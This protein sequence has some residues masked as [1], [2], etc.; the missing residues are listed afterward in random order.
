MSTVCIFDIYFLLYD[1]SEVHSYNVSQGYVMKPMNQSVQPFDQEMEPAEVAN[2]SADSNI[3]ILTEML[4]N[5]KQIKSQSSKS[6]KRMTFYSKTERI[7][8]VSCKVATMI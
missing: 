6:F 3:A 4:L 1:H 8:W 7:H 5:Q 2:I